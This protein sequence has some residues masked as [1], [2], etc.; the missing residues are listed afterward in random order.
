MSNLK[1]CLK[2]SKSILLH[3][4][5]SIKEIEQDLKNNKFIT[6]CTNWI[7]NNIIRIAKY[8]F[9][10]FA[11]RHISYKMDVIVHHFR[12]PVVAH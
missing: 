3:K 4:K 9:T 11:G 5:H 10:F 8:I 2:D 12:G 7:C 1:T 6:Y